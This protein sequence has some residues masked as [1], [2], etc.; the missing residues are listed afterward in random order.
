MHWKKGPEIWLQ[1]SPI[2]FYCVVILNY[3]VIP[4]VNIVMSIVLFIDPDFVLTQQTTETFV[5]FFFVICVMRVVEFFTL[6]R[7]S[8]LLDAKIYLESKREFSGYS[9][10]ELKKLME[11]LS[12]KTD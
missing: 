2:I 4:A 7:R 9:K 6:I 5:I 10:Q 3:L 1:V 11:E 8:V 12:E